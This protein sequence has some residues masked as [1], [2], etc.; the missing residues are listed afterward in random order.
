MTT[1]ADPQSLLLQIL[2]PA[3]RADPYPLYRRIREQ[4]AVH[5]PES[6]LAVFSSFADCDEVLRHP[7]SSSDRLKSTAA[8]RL[9]ADGAQARPLGPP[10]FLFLDPPDH[11]RLRRLVSKA[12]LPKVVRALEPEIARLVDGLL[13]EADST[14]ETFDAISGLAWKSVV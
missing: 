8:Q 5:M 2:D 12:F 6:N 11:T 4:G 9:I 13:N 14:S 3:H 7:S 1:S 10:G